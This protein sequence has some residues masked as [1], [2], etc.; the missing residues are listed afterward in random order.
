MRPLGAVPLIAPVTWVMCNRRG[1][2]YAALV[3][4]V[5]RTRGALMRPLRIMPLI[6]PATWVM[7]NRRGGIYAALVTYII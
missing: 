4:Y 5:V 2:N 7:C 3:A 1:G 6:A